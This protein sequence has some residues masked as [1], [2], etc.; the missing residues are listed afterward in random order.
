MVVEDQVRVLLM[1]LLQGSREVFPPALQE[2]KS[3]L[4]LLLALYK[5]LP[6]R[7][8]GI[9][10]LGRRA[11]NNGVETL[12]GEPVCLRAGFRWGVVNPVV[13]EYL[14]VLSKVFF[15]RG[16]AKRLLLGKFHAADTE[17]PR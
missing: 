17:G 8:L 6:E 12:D 1:N 13:V 9:Q 10:H 7:S 3:Y 5:G 15:L 16:I 4:Q 14:F 11:D 2:F